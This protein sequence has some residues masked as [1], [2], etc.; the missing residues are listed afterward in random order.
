MKEIFDA[1]GK[2][3]CSGSWRLGGRVQLVEDYSVAGRQG[4]ACS[5]GAKSAQLH[6]GRCEID[7]S[8]D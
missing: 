2:E 7:E 6:R 1:Y 5:G 8:A 4:I 3:C